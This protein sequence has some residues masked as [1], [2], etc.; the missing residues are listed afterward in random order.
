MAHFR[1]IYVGAAA[2][3]GSSILLGMSSGSG[4]L[5]KL[6][7]TVPQGRLNVA[8]LDTSGSD[9][10][11][12]GHDNGKTTRHEKRENTDDNG[13]PTAHSSVLLATAALT[14]RC[15]RLS[16]NSALTVMAYRTRRRPRF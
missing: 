12:R 7:S 14:A 9:E 16:P 5:L 3:I 1:T 11:G 6:N 4:R 2:A 13:T 15:R 8:L 10:T